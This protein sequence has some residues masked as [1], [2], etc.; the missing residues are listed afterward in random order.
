MAPAV[1]YDSRFATSVASA[2]IIRIKNRSIEAIDLAAVD[3]KKAQEALDKKLK[4]VKEIYVMT[5]ESVNVSKG[6]EVHYIKPSKKEGPRRVLEVWKREFPQAKTTPLVIH[7]LGKRNLTDEDKVKRAHIKNSIPT[8]LGKLDENGLHQ[9]NRL[10]KEPQDTGFL[11][12]LVA[13]G[14]IISDYKEL[15]GTGDTDTVSKKELQLAESKA[16]NLEDQAETVKELEVEVANLELKNEETSKEIKGLA[17]ELEET[18][19]SEGEANEKLEKEV[20]LHASTKDKLKNA[21]GETANAKSTVTDKEKKLKLLREDT[22]KAT[23]LLE[24]EKSDHKSTADTL[25]KTKVDLQASV[26]SLAESRKD[27]DKGQKDL[28][29]AGDSIK[30]L[31]KEVKDLKAKLKKATK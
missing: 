10:L 26:K 8:Y 17:K 5:D 31:E 27:Y 4:K 2:A 21:Q 1:I 29:K 25:K 20:E 24:K 22:G 9:W 3:S 19:D 11:A 23:A 13:N 14:Q 12:Q 28:V 16:K 18:Q 15:Y 30:K 6:T 7:Y